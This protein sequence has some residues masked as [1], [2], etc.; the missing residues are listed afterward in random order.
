MLV[1]VTVLGYDGSALSEE[2]LAALA[3]ADLVLGGSRHLDATPVPSTARTVVMGPLEPAVEQLREAH[4][5]GDRVVV[6][7]SGDPGLFGIVRNLRGWISDSVDVRVVPAV[8]SVAAAAARLGFAWDDALVVSAHGRRLEP[9]LNVVR[10]YGGGLRRV[11]VL[12]DAES[13]PDRIVEALGADCPDLHVLEHLGTSEERHTRIG[14]EPELGALSH[15]EA[16]GHVWE[17]PNVVVTWGRAAYP[18]ATW[19]MGHRG[20]HGR[21]GDLWAQPDEEFEHRDGMLTKREV[22]AVVLARLAPAVGTMVW[23]VGA[24]S[25]S[26]AVE[27]AR[28]GAAAVAIEK[29]EVALGHITANVNDHQVHLKVVH[30]EAPE[31]L[32]GLPHPDAV[33]VGGGG[34]DV[35]A[36]VADVRPD[37]IVVALATLERVAPT[38]A[39]LDG[40]DVDTVLLQVQHLTALGDG[41]RLSPANPVFVVSGTRS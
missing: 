41:H 16:I 23:D 25:G 8:S 22:R 31:A 27:C 2:A 39:A 29:N 7:A 3:S 36:A 10:R 9:A 26:V 33:F 24:G 34:P 28:L 20:G 30:G 15:D 12:T 5:R 21:Y 38:I 32:K 19:L 11:V 6:V 14:R 35:V 13:S 17:S 40:Y 4:R 1:P 37:R 18:D